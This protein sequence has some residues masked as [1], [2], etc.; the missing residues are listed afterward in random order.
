MYIILRALAGIIAGIAP[1]IHRIKAGTIVTATVGTT[2][3]FQVHDIRMGFRAIAVMTVC[4]ATVGGIT[5]MGDIVL[6]I[7]V[8]CA[9]GVILSILRRRLGRRIRFGR[10]CVIFFCAGLLRC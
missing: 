2:F 6:G 8:I 7:I 4:A 5:A 9:A 1:F 3:Q 10:L